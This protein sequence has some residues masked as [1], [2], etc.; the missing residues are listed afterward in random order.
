M[1]SAGELASASKLWL[2]CRDWLVRTFDSLCSSCFGS[3]ARSAPPGLR[4]GRPRGHLPAARARPRNDARNIRLHERPSLFPTFRLLFAVTYRLAGSE[5]NRAV[6]RPS[7]RDLMTQSCRNA[8]WRLSNHM[9]SHGGGGL[10]AA[11]WLISAACNATSLTCGCGA[12]H[13]SRTI[14]DSPC[15]LR[16][17]GCGMVQFLSGVSPWVSIEY[18]APRGVLFGGKRNLAGSERTFF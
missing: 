14:S 16:D 13:V 10:H 8:R 6:A 1:T 7:S 12:F 18:F 2:S 17:G 3:C 11:G 4:A 5:R 15:V 9:T